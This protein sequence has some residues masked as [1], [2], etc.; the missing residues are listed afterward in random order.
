MKNDDPLVPL[1]LVLE[2]NKSLTAEDIIEA[3]DKHGVPLLCQVE[4]PVMVCGFSQLLLKFCGVDPH[5]NAVE[6]MRGFDPIHNNSKTSS[7]KNTEEGFSR[8]YNE[9]FYLDTS[10]LE[11]ENLKSFNPP[12]IQRLG[13]ESSLKYISEHILSRF[14]NQHTI[15]DLITIQKKELFELIVSF[16]HEYNNLFYTKFINEMTLG[17]YR[18]LVKYVHSSPKIPANSKLF[19]VPT[20]SN[21]KSLFGESK[22]F[23]AVFTTTLFLLEEAG[24]TRL[25]SLQHKE[26]PNAE[27]KD[28]SRFERP[29]PSI[30]NPE[31]MIVKP[32][33]YIFS[34]DVN[35]LT[36]TLITHIENLYEQKIESD[37]K[38]QSLEI[39]EIKKRAEQV[40]ARPN[41]SI[42]QVY[43][44]KSDLDKM[45]WSYYSFRPE[46]FTEDH[47]SERLKYIIKVFFDVF[48]KEQD[49]PTRITKTELEEI[50]R[51]HS[52][53]SDHL[54]NHPG[55]LAYDAAPEFAKLLLSAAR[56]ESTA[57]KIDH[58]TVTDFPQNFKNLISLVDKMYKGRVDHL[59]NCKYLREV[60]EEEVKEFFKLEALYSNKII[61]L[62]LSTIRPKPFNKGRFLQFC[63]C[64]HRPEY[65][66]NNS[67][68]GES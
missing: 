10:I 2:R 15:D 49:E 41:I 55:K 34:D 24:V 37:K 62:Y 29:E 50:L 6:L 25:K 47:Y 7:E 56:K 18:E 67:I 26:T 3:Q 38:I 48:V 51:G 42:D 12:F 43:L 59:C 66:C 31:A 14:K 5:S 40:I 54:R 60:E 13:D 52:A 63:N 35:S 21:I 20:S 28:T 19:F 30:P 9:T 33:A 8:Y 39:N 4:S 1:T 64:S 17:S 61:S 58:R 45:N 16:I 27:Q 57:Y 46:F 36:D 22:K 65:Q 32:S 11:F 23:E 53:T 44:A 68:E